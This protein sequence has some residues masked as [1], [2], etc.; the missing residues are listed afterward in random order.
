[1]KTRFFTFLLCCMTAWSGVSAQK[2]VSAFSNLS[3]G[4]EFFSFTGFGIELA[5]PLSPNFA[6][7]G[8]VSILPIN[9]NITFKAPV[10]QGIINE[11][12]NAITTSQ[13]PVS[14]I[15]AENGLP[16]KAEDISTDVNTTVSL[17]FVNGKLLFDYYPSANHAFHITAGFYIGSSQLIKLKGKMDQAV[18]VLNVLKDNGVLDNNGKNFID[19]TYVIDQENGYQLTGNDIK[20]ITGSL[21]INTVKPYLGLGFGRAVP[22][23]RVGVTFE[24]GAFYQGTPA[25]KSDNENIQKLI[26]GELSGVTETL[27]KLPIYPVLSL[28]LNFRII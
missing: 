7:R 5:T 13:P 10:D 6:L 17:N 3:L 22:K 18:D 11:I 12:N 15:L 25:L 23:S 16:T 20:N 8:G 21:N 9:Y 19:R 2:T 4:V 1:M 24:I 27:N 28:K 26:D 14:T